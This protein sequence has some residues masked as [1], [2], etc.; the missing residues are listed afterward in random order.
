MLTGIPGPWVA[1]LHHWNGLFPGWTEF[2]K[3]LIALEKSGLMYVLQVPRTPDQEMEVFLAFSQPLVKPG[4]DK[5]VIEPF[6]V[7]TA[8]WKRLQP[9]RLLIGEDGYILMLALAH[10]H[11][12]QTG[13]P[14]GKGLDQDAQEI[15]VDV[16]GE[17]A[18]GDAVVEAH[19]GLIRGVYKYNVPRVR[20]VVTWFEPD[21]EARDRL[22]HSKVYRA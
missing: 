13:T 8:Y 6:P 5:I 17:L 3:Q 20:E 4:E 18:S 10:I 16:S 9:S 14:L 2:R 21:K 19:V 22:A 1:L 15:G 12:F 11:F 7:M